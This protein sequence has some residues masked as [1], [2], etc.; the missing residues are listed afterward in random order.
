MSK[1][2]GLASLALAV[3]CSDSGSWGAGGLRSPDGH[4]Q[5]RLVTVD[6]V[7]QVFVSFENDSCGGGSVSTLSSDPKIELRWRDASTL[8]VLAPSGLDLEPAP[9]ASSLNHEIRCLDRTVSVVVRQ[10]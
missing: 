8:E 4:A 2:I 3:G 5:A 1:L 7:T 9:A 6:T 10:Q